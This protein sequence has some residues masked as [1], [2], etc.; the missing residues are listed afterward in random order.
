MWWGLKPRTDDVA[1]ADVPPRAGE[2]V[3]SERRVAVTRRTHGG[4]D[5]RAARCVGELPA[6]GDASTL[7]RSSAPEGSSLR[8]PSTVI[9]GPGP[10]DEARDGSRLHGGC[11]ARIA[12]PPTG[13]SRSQVRAPRAPGSVRPA[14]NQEHRE[15]GQGDRCHSKAD[16]CCRSRRGHGSHREPSPIDILALIG[17]RAIPRVSDPAPR[18]GS[19]DN[20]M[21]SPGWWVRHVAA[22]RRP[23]ASVG[24]T[25]SA[26]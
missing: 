22:A 4:C 5:V 6:G 1:C 7:Q 23:S 25:V 15:G 14:G 3:L 8:Q 12:R 19:P 16:R 17:G 11:C 21:P 18:Q 2:Q 24:R 9:S 10:V 13:G 20:S 26:R